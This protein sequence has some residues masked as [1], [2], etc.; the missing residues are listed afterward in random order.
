MKRIVGSLRWRL[1]LWHA[2]ILLLVIT[3]L[4]LLAWRVASDDRMRRVDRELGRFERTLFGTVMRPKNGEETRK[5]DS[6]PSFAEIRERFRTLQPDDTWPN[7]LRALFDP[8]R[9]EDP[10]Y[11]LWDDDGELLFRSAN[12]PAEIAIP[13]TRDS[14]P[15]EETRITGNR[16]EKIQISPRGSRSVTGREVSSDL[17]EL[18]QLAVVL[19]LCGTG[20]WLLGLVGGWWLAGRAL[21]PIDAIGRTASRIAGGNLAERIHVAD[22]D[23]ELDRLSRVLNGTFDRLQGAI[24]RQTQFTA[25]ASHELRTPLSVILCE[26]QR[27]LKRER[28]PEEYREILQTCRQSGERM[29][30]LVESLLILARHDDAPAETI[31]ATC[32][33]TAIARECVEHLAPLAADKGSTITLGETDPA[34]ICQGNPGE[35]AMLLTNLL[36]NAIHHTPAGSAVAVRVATTPGHAVLEVSD[37]GPGISAEHLPR[38][39]DRFYRADKTRSSAKGHTGLGLAIAR[40]VA[41][42]HHGAIEVSSDT[43]TGTTFRVTLP[44]QPPQA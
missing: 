22:S 38:L 1:Q 39:F 44:M 40:A 41:E 21:K 3:A 31:R 26:T 17:A 11:A 7:S 6:P 30:S 23:D 36:S 35:L 4:C 15:G 20:V 13:R 16:R 32:D 42:S 9:T 19:A 28:P 27:A 14:G 8:T 12:A 24:Q 34:A 25:D 43:G 2:L 33:L 37:N 10:Y 5:E 18:R 29:R